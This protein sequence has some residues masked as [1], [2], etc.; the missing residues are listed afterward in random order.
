MDLTALQAQDTFHVHQ[1]LTMMINRYEVFAD[2][3]GAPGE[4]VAFVEQKRL[5]FK[6]QVTLFADRERQ[7]VLARFKARKVIDVHGGYD[8]TD[9]EGGPIGVFTKQFKASLLRSTWLL[10]QPGLEPVTVTERSQG[11][12]L[13]RRLWDWIPW[14]GDFPFPIKYHFDWLRGTDRIGAFD[15]VTRLRDHYIVHVDDPALDRRLVIAQAVAL[16]ALQ[17]R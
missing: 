14:A 6:E 17:S 13:F 15:K 5:A 12:A 7:T 16:D 10:E 1:K 3:A 9:P 8:V 11:L 4:L 2:E